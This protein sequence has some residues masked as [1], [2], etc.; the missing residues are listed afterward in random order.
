VK[1]TGLSLTLAL[2]ALLAPTVSAG[3]PLKE[4]LPPPEDAVHPAG[5]V[6]PFPLGEEVLSNRGKSITF[7]NGSQLVTG[8][9]KERLTNLDTGESIDVNVSGPGTFTV[10]GDVLHVVG[11]GAWL[12]LAAADEPGGPGAL[13]IHGHI[14][15]DVDLL[16]GA[17][18]SL[19]VRGTTRDLCDVLA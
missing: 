14:R 3:K 17:P 9:L 1:R 7:S 2:F 6:C 10:E 5:L 4:P 16:T 13:F 12:L 8:T 18:T 11:R 15:F 19:Q